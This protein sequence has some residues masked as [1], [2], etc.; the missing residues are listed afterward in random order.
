MKRESGSAYRGGLPLQ[1]GK[2]IRELVAHLAPVDDHIDCALLEQELRTL[3]ALG[4]LLAHGLLDDARPGETDERTRFGN[5]DITDHGEACRHPAHGRVGENRDEREL[6]RS[7]LC[8]GGGGLGHLH[9]RKKPFLHAR[10]TGRRN[11]HQRQLLVEARV[12]PTHEALPHS[13]PHRSAHELE[14]ESGD[15]ERHVFYGALHHDQGF[16]FAGGLLGLLEPVRIT[17]VVLEF[18]TV[19]RRDLDPNFEAPFRVEKEVE[20]YPCRNTVVIAA[21]GA[22]IGVLFEIG[23]IQ[24]C[25]ARGALAPQTFRDVFLRAGSGAVD[26]GWKQLLEPAHASIA[27]RI[28]LSKVAAFSTQVLGEACSISWII[29]LPITTASAIWATA[30][31]VCPSRMPSPTPTGSLVL[32]RIAGNFAATSSKSRCLAP[33]TPRSDT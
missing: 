2:K 32:P 10:A 11:A 33:V 13:R 1:N 19:D 29:L 23:C 9:E 22:D 31:A 4:E 16:G 14:L 6:A 21:F 3:K 15:D 30:R 17:F 18:Q 5:H 26:L 7:E 24:D 20:P 27:L 28:S 12:H 8:Q 25:R